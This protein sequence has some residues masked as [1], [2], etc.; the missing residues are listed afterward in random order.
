MA[1]WRRSAGTS[2]GIGGGAGRTVDRPQRRGHEHHDVDGEQR[3][4]GGQRDHE[5][6]EAAAGLAELGQQQ[7]PATVDRVGDRAAAE[8]EDQRRQQLDDREGADGQ[9]VAGE[10]IHLVRDRDQRERPPDRADALPDP[11]EPEVAVEPQR[12]G[13]DE[14]AAEPAA[15]R[16]RLVGHRVHGAIEPP[17]VT[18]NIRQTVYTIKEASARSGVGAPLIRAWERRYGVVNPAGRTPAGYRLYDDDAVRGAGR[19]ADA[20]RLGLDGLGGRAGDHRGRGRRRRPRAAGRRPASG[21]PARQALPRLAT[22]ATLM[23]E[24]FVAAAEASS[25]PAPRPPST[26]CSRRARSSRSSTTSSCRPRRRSATPGRA[27]GSA[28]A[29]STPRARRSAG[30]SVQ[31]SRPPA[32][33][34]RCRW[35]SGCRRARA[36]SSGAL[37]FA[38]ALRRRGVG[39]LYLGPDVTVDGWID[40]MARTR[41]RAAV[42]G[43]VTDAD[44]GSAAPSRRGAARARRAAGRRR[45]GGGLGRRVGVEGPGAVRMP[46]RVVEA[47][48][49][50]AEAVVGALTAELISTGR[51]PGDLGVGAGPGS[52]EPGHEVPQAPAVGAPRAGSTGRGRTAAGG[53]RGTAARRSLPR[54]GASP[55]RRSCRCPAAGDR[56]S[57]RMTRWKPGSD[58]A[59]PGVSAQPGCIAAN[60]TDPRIRRDHS[61]ISATWARFARRVR[62]RPVVVAAGELRSSSGSRCVYMP[63]EVTAITRDPGVWREERLEATPRAR[64]GRRP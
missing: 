18:D 4:G 43:V 38:A 5:E 39:V 22:T 37:A 61:R 33:R 20:G 57:G 27:A 21:R 29:A 26:R 53:G 51:A 34:A 25:A 17:A 36:T 3:R 49:A 9:E 31:R 45:R 56:S 50:V 28:S 62:P 10:H 14:D 35:S 44:R 2:R 30:G 54:P 59:R 13:V 12:R 64:T 11:E 47:A 8:R 1:A 46:D 63:P 48:A 40:A 42:V 23:V 41:A 60:A 19:D 55:A 32:C 52:C 16:A 15:R 6:G 24:R 7:Q 58:S